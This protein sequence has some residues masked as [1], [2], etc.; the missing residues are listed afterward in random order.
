MPHVCQGETNIHNGVYYGDTLGV[1]K[2]FNTS[3]GQIIA[4]ITQFFLCSISIL[5]S[6]FAWRNTLNKTAQITIFNNSVLE[7]AQSG[8]SMNF[9]AY[10]G[11]YT[12]KVYTNPINNGTI[13]WARRE[14]LL[15]CL[16]C[17]IP[18]FQDGILISPAA[19]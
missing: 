10:N 1:G 9:S 18:V 8:Q 14:G 17:L 3:T 6:I 13:Y 11:T 5:I 19:S 16:T 12:Y 4:N 7:C 2:I 15:H